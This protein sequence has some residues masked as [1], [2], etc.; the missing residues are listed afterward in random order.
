MRA[1]YSSVKDTGLVGYFGSLK[2]VNRAIVKRQTCAGSHSSLT[3]IIYSPDLAK[4]R[5]LN[6][7]EFHAYFL[8]SSFHLGKTVPVYF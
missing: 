4:I 2:G 6:I 5:I 8:K 7:L 3:P 1:C